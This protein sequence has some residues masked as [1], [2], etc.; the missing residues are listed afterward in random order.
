MM[1]A[2]EQ[3]SMNSLGIRFPTA[4]A[5][6]ITNAEECS[7]L[8]IDGRFDRLLALNRTVDAILAA[9]IDRSRV[10]EERDRRKDEELAKLVSVQKRGHV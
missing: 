1:S 9:R 7:D 3:D 6:A 2:E 5:T 8:T 4:A 10:I